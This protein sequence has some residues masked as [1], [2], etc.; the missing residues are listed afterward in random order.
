L[1]SLGISLAKGARYKVQGVVAKEEPNNASL[2]QVLQP[3]IMRGL[4]TIP[5]KMRSWQNLTIF[6]IHKKTMSFSSL[7]LAL[8][9]KPYLLCA[10]SASNK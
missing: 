9:L 8:N 10:L 3:L 5:K 4:V 7:P 2:R 6:F 1:L